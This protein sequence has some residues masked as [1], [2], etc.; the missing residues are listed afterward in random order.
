MLSIVSVAVLIFIC[1]TCQNLHPSR[2]I[3]VDLH[4]TCILCTNCAC[5]HSLYCHMFCMQVRV[6]V[7]GVF[8]AAIALSSPGSLQPLRVCVDSAD[9]ASLLDPW[10]HSKHQV[11]T[12]CLTVPL[13]YFTCHNGQL[14]DPVLVLPLCVP[15]VAHCVSNRWL[16]LK[17]Q[18]LLLC[19]PEG[20]C[21]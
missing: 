4:H 13:D 12:G 19:M 21:V 1:V 15:K 16:C 2:P 8:A 14:P 6:V 18:L 10:T 7:P 3:M 5:T 9:K 17:V 20:A 11:N